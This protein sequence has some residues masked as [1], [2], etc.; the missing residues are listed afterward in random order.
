MNGTQLL[1]ALKFHGLTGDENGHMLVVLDVWCSMPVSVVVHTTTPDQSSEHGLDGARS[2]TMVVSANRVDMERGRP[3]A[4][5][6]PTVYGDVLSDWETLLDRGLELACLGAAA[7]MAKAFDEAGFDQEK[8]LREIGAQMSDEDR[9]HHLDHR[10]E[11]AVLR[12]HLVEKSLF[13]MGMDEGEVKDMAKMVLDMSWQAYEQ[14]VA[15][16]SKKDGQ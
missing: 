13:V 11:C 5:F 9:A 2:V 6:A 8:F 4:A 16:L 3:F 12:Q 15:I 1:E 7:Y 14:G 10:L